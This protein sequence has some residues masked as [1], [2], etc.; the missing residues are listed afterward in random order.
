MFGA[1]MAKVFGMVEAENHATTGKQTR[2]LNVGKIRP[3]G[4]AIGCYGRL[5]SDPPGGS[6]ERD[7]A[8]RDT[9]HCGDQ[10]GL[11]EN[12]GRLG[13]VC[14]PP[15]EEFPR[16]V[17]RDAT[18]RTQRQPKRSL[19]PEHR[20]RPLRG[21][22]QRRDRKRERNSSLNE[23]EPRG[24]H[25]KTPVTQHNV[26]TGSGCRSAEAPG[27]MYRGEWGAQGCS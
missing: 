9:A 5:G 22:A 21:G 19:I 15:G 18:E 27:T 26:E 10:T 3:A 12:A 11:I 13:P 7:E 17:K 2:R 4:R 25:R 1:V 23:N 16:G 6:P 24:W 20:R 8:G 14:Q